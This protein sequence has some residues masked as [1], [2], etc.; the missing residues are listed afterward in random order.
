MTRAD[1]H[2]VRETKFPGF[3]EQCT[4]KKERGGGGVGVG[5]RL[6]EGEDERRLDTR[7]R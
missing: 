1:E 5:V 2:R 6:L 3:L 4:V 7:D